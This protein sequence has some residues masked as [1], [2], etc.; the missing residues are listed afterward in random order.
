M[1]VFKYFKADELLP[2]WGGGGQL[3]NSVMCVISTP[4]PVA[5]R[6]KE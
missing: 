1:G 5:A 2:L 3:A 6:S 4:T